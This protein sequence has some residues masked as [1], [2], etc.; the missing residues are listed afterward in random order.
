VEAIDSFDFKP[1][2]QALQV[3]VHLMTTSA[4]N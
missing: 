3:V 4:K 1:V 2:E